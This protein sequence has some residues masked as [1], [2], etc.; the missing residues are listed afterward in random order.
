MKRWELTREFILRELRGL[1]IKVRTEGGRLP[2][3]GP[4]PSSPG[5][6]RCRLTLQWNSS[7]L[8][9]GNRMCRAVSEVSSW[10]GVGGSG[11]SSCVFLASPAWDTQQQDQSTWAV[12][13]AWPAHASSVVDGHVRFQM[14][15]PT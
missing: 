10:V 8:R 15:T 14:L 13:A 3:L 2:A 6:R 11:S 7:N 12:S 1:E 9:G 5:G 4:A